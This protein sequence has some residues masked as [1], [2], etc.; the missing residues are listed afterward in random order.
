M[1][2][3]INATLRINHGNLWRSKKMCPVSP[4][5]TTSSPS[6]TKIISITSRR[7]RSGVNIGIY[8][9]GKDS[10]PTKLQLRSDPLDPHLLQANR[11]LRP[12]ARIAR[13][14]GN[15]VRHVLPFHYL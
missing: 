15:L 5:H 9:M 13:S 14:V 10:G 12:V 3:R 6:N 11:S 4:S 1:P 7:S 2:H 8:H